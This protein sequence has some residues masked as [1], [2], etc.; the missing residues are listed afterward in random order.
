MTD[1]SA[2]SPDPSA[3]SSPASS[4]VPSSP[5]PPLSVLE[6]VGRSDGSS[7]AQAIE[8]AMRTAEEA[9]RLGYERYWFAEHH[10]TV[11]FQ[12]SA[13]TVLMANAAAR[14]ERIRIGSGGVMLPNHAPLAVA[15]QI[16]T[17]ATMH[18]GRVDL[19]LG[20]APGTDP[21]T[22]SLLRRGEA[23]PQSFAR[24]ILALRG[25]FS[26][27]NAAPG[28]RVHAVPAGGTD[29]P[30]WVLGSS[31]NGASI[32]GQLGLPFSFASH[33]APQQLAEAVAIYR[34]S[35]STESPTAQIS[36]P[37]LMVGVN[38]MV[39]ETE[40]KA[41][42]LFTTHQQMAAGIVTGQRQLLQPP[43]D[44]ITSVVPER[45]LAQIAGMQ[46]V[47]AIG[48]AEQVVERLAGIADATG[49]DEII[50]VTYTYDP[51]DR[52]TSLRLL[53]EAWGPGAA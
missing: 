22:A 49:A 8:S 35:F 3:V 28:S 21:V 19:G 9:D 52:L 43:V 23:D 29:V 5:R 15:E 16:G 1:S 51:D 39:A 45:V 42:R 10:N 30:I 47:T 20:R 36:E 12:S 44:D 53:A 14:T 31:V 34:A 38:V 37:R 6:L 11:T 18:P 32:A 25:Y 26:E 4:P 24:E 7:A 46:T 2:P 41:Q 17:I 48:T 13:T 33:F 27:A 40:E 50:T